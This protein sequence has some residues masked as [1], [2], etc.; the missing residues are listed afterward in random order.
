[1]KE[2]M[3]TTRKGQAVL[4]FLGLM[5]GTL[6]GTGL[7]IFPSVFEPVLRGVILYLNYENH[8][9]VHYDPSHRA[10]FAIF[11]IALGVFWFV[12][13]IIAYVRE[14]ERNRAIDSYLLSRNR[15]DDSR[16]A[17]VIPEDDQSI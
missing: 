7:M 2:P 17:T 6:A 5:A 3:G 13:F 9:S 11:F 12:L 15:F 14:P 16:R 4:S 1:M 10:L 8:T